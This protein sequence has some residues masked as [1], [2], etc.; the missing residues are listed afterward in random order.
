MIKKSN[1]KKVILGV[2]LLASASILGYF[3][4]FGLSPVSTAVAE[5]STF[6]LVSYE[7]GEDVSSFV[8]I[9]VW[10][11]D[12]DEKFDDAEDWYKKSMFDEEISSKDADDV[13][14]D[15]TG[16]DYVWIEIDPDA[17]SVFET[18]WYIISGGE[19]SNTEY[20]LDVFHLSSDVHLT[21]SSRAGSEG[22]DGIADGNYTVIM[23]FPGYTI[24]NTHVGDDWDMDDDDWDDLDS[25][26][27]LDYYDER[28][29]RNQA[30]NY[31]LGDDT[32]NDFEDNVE[33]LTE[34][35][36]LKLVFNDTIS[37]TDG[38][39]TQINVSIA[40]SEPVET[41]TSGTFLFIVFYEPISAIATLD[42]E[43]SLAV[44]ITCS[45]IYSGR[46]AVP[47]DINSIGTLT[48]YSSSISF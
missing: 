31:V 24:T 2:A 5:E 26:D 15:L 8:E 38:E 7:D 40:D 16:Y 13:E 9:S 21:T 1:R 32:N 41:A 19:G 25:D 46:L 28:N 48:A 44:N 20:S 3:L 39:A 45:Y 47:G 27:K 10:I 14:I 30:P 22:W 43:I 6:N 35:Y 36:A 18:T 12:P 4:F 33:Q 34:A 11:P 37:S 42:F 17:E 23:D 29:W